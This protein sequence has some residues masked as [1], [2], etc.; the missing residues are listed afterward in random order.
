MSSISGVD[1]KSLL[2]TILSLNKAEDV[3]SSS[4]DS[5]ENEEVQSTNS[6]LTLSLPDQ[7]KI[8]FLQSQCSFI[9]S[10]FDS[11]ISSSPDSLTSFFGDEE[12]TNILGISQLIAGS[13]NSSSTSSTSEYITNL[14]QSVNSSTSTQNDLDA[15]QTTIA[16][17]LKSSVNSGG[18]SAQEILE[19]YLSSSTNG[20]ALIK[21]A[22]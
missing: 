13:L 4:N 14:L 7:L 2:N 3:N 6:G 11:D 16:S 18:S 1:T 17:L 9:T 8:L 15:V 12:S 5:S 10:I 19:K 22:V 21:T 20:S